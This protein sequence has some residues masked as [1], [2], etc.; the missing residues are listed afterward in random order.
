MQVILLQ[1][2]PKVGRKYEIKTV[3][4]GYAQ[5]HLLPRQ[6]AEAA[7]KNRVAQLTKKREEAEQAHKAEYEE[8][9]KMFKEL[10]GNSVHVEMK[11]NEQGHLFQAIKH[12]DIA[13]SINEKLGSALK[14][15]HVTRQEQIKDIGEYELALEH[16]DLKAKVK[17]VVKK[18]G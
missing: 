6:L 3:A 16:D 14:P 5:N 17:F 18:E 8:I 9:K 12:D 10:E 1:D 15:E 11:A 7:T 13:Q 4:N 2:V